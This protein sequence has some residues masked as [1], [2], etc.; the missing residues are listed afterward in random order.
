MQGIA[1]SP[2]QR[3][4]PLISES[5]STGFRQIAVIPN[6][7]VGDPHRLLSGEKRTSP[8]MIDFKVGELDKN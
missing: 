8:C 2:L 6:T 4:L 3:L 5:R 1:R 7:T